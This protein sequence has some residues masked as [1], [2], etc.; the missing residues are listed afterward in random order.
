MKEKRNPHPGK[1]PNWQ[2]DQL[3]RR[4][5]EVTK[6]S[7][8]AGLRTAKQSKNRTNHLNHWPGH[9]SL[10]SLG[11]G[12]ALRLRLLRLVLGRGLGLAEWGQPEGVR[13]SVPWVG[14]QYTTG[15]GGE[16]HGRGNPG[17]VLGLQERQV[18]GRGAYCHR[19]LPVPERVHACRF[20]GWGGVGVGGGGGVALVQ[21]PG[22]E[23]PLAHLGETGRFLCSY[24][25][26]GTSCVG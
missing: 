25:W 5:L 26:L 24:W 4:D 14:E 15:W 17:E 11:G 10:R 12:W 8:A 22:G 13:S 1:P 3:S 2:K 23:K 18:R 20:W 21:A 16:H 19:K 6:K 7:A 9:H